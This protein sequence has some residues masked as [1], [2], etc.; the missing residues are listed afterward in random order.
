MLQDEMIVVVEAS[1]VDVVIEDPPDITVIP[2]V[3]PDVILL[4]AGGIG[5]PGPEGPEGPDGPVGPQ[6]EV[7]PQGPYGPEGPQG[8]QGE[9][10]SGITMKGSQPTEEDLPPTG[11]DLGDAYLVEEDDSLWIWDGGGWI[12]GGSIQGPPGV[13]G[14]TGPQGIQGP[15]GDPGPAGADGA[16]GPAG[17]SSTLIPS[18][19]V[20][21]T[22]DFNLVAATDTLI[23]F[24]DVAFEETD[25]W[26]SGAS[27][28]I[29]VIE[30]GK[31]Q[32]VVTATFD[33]HATSGE[34]L[35]TVRKNGTTQVASFRVL[36]VAGA[37][38]PSALIS[39]FLNLAAGD[40]LE[41]IAWASHATK[42]LAYAG[43]PTFE[44]VK[45]D[46]IGPPGP[47]GPGGGVDY[48]GDWAAPTVYKK[49]DVV[50]HAGIDYLAVNDSSGQVP[51]LASPLAP[52]VVCLFDQIL[53]VAA[54]SFDIQNISQAYSHLEIVVQGRSDAAGNSTALLVR[55][56]NDSGANYDCG[57][58][59][60]S[61]GTVARSDTFGAAF[62]SLGEIPAAA[63]IA[64]GVG[65]YEI[66]LQNYAQVFLNKMI[67]SLGGYKYGTAAGNLWEF[68]ANGFWRNSA[69]INRVT[70]YPNA[71]N[72]VAGSRLT[73][74]GRLSSGQPQPVTTLAPGGVGIAFPDSPTNGETFTL[75][76]SLSAPTYAWDFRYV[77]SITD[78]YK[79]VF[80]GGAPLHIGVL[81]IQAVAAANIWTHPTAPTGPEWVSA[82]SGEYDVAFSCTTTSLGAAIAAAMGVANA[83][84]GLT[85]V[86]ATVTS[87]NDNSQYIGLSARTRMIMSIGQT[88]RAVHYVQVAGMQVQQRVISIVP[89]RLS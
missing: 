38:Y 63:A 88:M 71:G 21:R 69:A 84:V 29:T 48:I 66:K 79:W 28:R 27:T 9:A 7:G 11:N 1:E 25:M 60:S 70:V 89:V 32:V 23:P 33:L 14:P 80:I 45:A 81:G 17:P 5:P 31:Y 64:G 67:T 56:N 10:G 72:F 59:Y 40:Y 85:P 42:V 20:Y 6:G 35:I 2:E 82:R 12:S 43:G 86:G 53:G 54:P 73:I 13:Q 62:I 52:G 83:S 65:S 26:N 30:S 44:L 49:G 15:E 47:T 36:S 24:T 22:V 4:T 51:P 50:R 18:V 77:A 19:R 61:S 76:D 34:R 8:P 39:E 16:P 55:L 58:L 74:Y 3:A 78:A 46:R 37:N 75:V 57:R 41:V 68:L 87:S